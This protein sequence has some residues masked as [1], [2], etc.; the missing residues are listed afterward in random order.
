MATWLIGPGLLF[1][2]PRTRAVQGRVGQDHVVHKGIQGQTAHV[3]GQGQTRHL[4]YG[5]SPCTEIS[6]K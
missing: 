6:A 1:A 5:L 2:P 3:G 4:A